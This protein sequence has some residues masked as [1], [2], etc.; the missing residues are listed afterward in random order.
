M[1]ILSTEGG[2]GKA[3]LSVATMYTD[4][5]FLNEALILKGFGTL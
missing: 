1:E 2:F 5:F 3:A 4:F